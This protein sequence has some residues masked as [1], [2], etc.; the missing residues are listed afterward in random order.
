MR[1][2]LLSLF[3]SLI[4]CTTKKPSSRQEAGN[5]NSSKSINTDSL[6]KEDE[7]FESFLIKF[8]KMEYPCSTSLL[9]QEKFLLKPLS[10]TRFIMNIK[11]TLVVDFQRAP[12]VLE[13]NYANVCSTF[14]PESPEIIFTTKDSLAKTFYGLQLASSND[15]IILMMNGKGFDDSYIFTYK[16]NGDLI[17]GLQCNARCVNKHAAFKRTSFID[18]KLE[19]NVTDFQEFGVENENNFEG[20]MIT[21][22]YGIDKYGVFF[23]KSEIINKF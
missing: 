6:K 7:S 19:I 12:K 5:L 4:F 23:K 1:V 8:Q 17:S 18:N 9:L 16:K 15:Y 3:I 21:Y 10:K 20:F 22:L 11:D 2:I 13:G 14:L